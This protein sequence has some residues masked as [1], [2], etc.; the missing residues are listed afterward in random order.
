MGFFFGS[1]LIEPSQ[2]KIISWKGNRPQENKKGRVGRGRTGE[3]SA[4]VKGKETLFFLRAKSSPKNA[5]CVCLARCWGEKVHE[6]TP[7]MPHL[8]VRGEFAYSSGDP[9]LSPG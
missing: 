4:S 3:G 1:S 9:L 7:R 2:E 5:S 8:A 6:A